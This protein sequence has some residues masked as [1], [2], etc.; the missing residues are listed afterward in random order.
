MDDAQQLQTRLGANVR[1]KRV[2]LGWTQAELGRRAN[3]PRDEI[4]RIE[5]GR[6]NVTMLA[7]VPA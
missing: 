2:A 7:R 3:I 1:P 4:S 5:G 6:L